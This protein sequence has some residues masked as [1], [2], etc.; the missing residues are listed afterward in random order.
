MIEEVKK[1]TTIPGFGR[2]AFCY[3]L[4]NYVRRKNEDKKQCSVGG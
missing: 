3:A 2:S 1:E 4:K